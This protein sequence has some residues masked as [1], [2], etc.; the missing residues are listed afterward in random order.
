MSPAI[1]CPD[2]FAQA[3]RLARFAHST[4]GTEGTT[5]LDLLH[6]WRD[7]YQIELS[8]GALAVIAAHVAVGRGSQHIGHALREAA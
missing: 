6:Q 3:E 1:F 5:L 8:N 4:M 2:P 7:G